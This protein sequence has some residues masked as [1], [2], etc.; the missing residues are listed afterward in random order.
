MKM[1]ILA[2]GQRSTIS[3][4][5]EGMPKPMLP[6]GGR[7]LLWHIMKHASLCGINDFIICGGY[8][9]DVIKD[10]FLDFYIYQ[11]DI[12]VNTRDNT[13]KIL[14]KHTEDW[15]VMIVDTGI[16]T[17]PIERIERVLEAAGEEFFVTY[18]D[19]LS[20][21][22]LSRLQELHQREAKDITIAV[23][24][25]SGRKTPLH[26]M[27]GED[28]EW[29]SGDMAWIS[30]GLFLAKQEV[31]KNSECSGD[32]EDVLSHSL[33]AV[34]RHEGYFS[35]IETLRD[36]SAAEALWNQGNAPWMGV[37]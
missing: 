15:N 26:F 35:T 23:A 6:I 13:V 2:G 3:E 20:D 14:N 25:P 12:L 22:S 8:R 9:I 36:K 10:Y 16:K 33:S 7:P 27:N 32:I 18:G 30:A 21:I 31:F 17:M 5:P 4:E 37:V 11:S 19:C 24:K 1:I 28:T 29:R 34:Y